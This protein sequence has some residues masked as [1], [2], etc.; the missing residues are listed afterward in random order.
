MIHTAS[1]G[2]FVVKDDYV[3]YWLNDHSGYFVDVCGG[4][5]DRAVALYIE[6][7]FP[8]RLVTP[9]LCQNCSKDHHKSAKVVKLCPTLNPLYERPTPGQYYA[10]MN[11]IL[12]SEDCVHCAWQHAFPSGEQGVQWEADPSDPFGW[13]LPKHRKLLKNCTVRQRD[14]YFYGYNVHHLQ[15][16][17]DVGPDGVRWPGFESSGLFSLPLTV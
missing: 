15:R 11:Q 7:P 6:S 10:M 9:Y 1:W 3:K 16:H 12:H 8:W 5:W 14:A 17:P 13:R 2:D 4:S